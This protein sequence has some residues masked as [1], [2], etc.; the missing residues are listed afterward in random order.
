VADNGIG[1]PDTIDFRATETL[2]LDLVVALAEEQ[3]EGSISM[4]K[5]GGT[6]FTI[7]FEMD[8]SVLQ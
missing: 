4:D 8:Y 3:L 2:G 5:T 1:I 6:A 7:T